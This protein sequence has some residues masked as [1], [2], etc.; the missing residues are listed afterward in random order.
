M[1]REDCKRKLGS[2]LCYH[3]MSVRT[4]FC[5]RFMFLFTWHSGNYRMD[6][7][8][9]AHVTCQE[10]TDL[11]L[12]LHLFDISVCLF[13][14]LLFLRNA[15]FRFSFRHSEYLLMLALYTWCLPKISHVLFSLRLLLFISQNSLDSSV[16]D[17]R[18]LWLND[19]SW[20]AYRGLNVI[21]QI[22][23]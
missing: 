1:F 15:I 14:M 8:G 9:N 6:S 21:S 4:C 12:S 16:L 22:P 2:C 20:F 23:L 7:L 18:F 17:L 13:S 19:F 10:H 3:T 5:L 11:L